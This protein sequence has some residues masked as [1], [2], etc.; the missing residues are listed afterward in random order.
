L[1]FN[2]IKKE[3][4]QDKIIQQIKNQIKREILKPGEKLPS[5][6]KLVDLLGVSRASIRE[7]VQA[8][9]FSGYL[10]VV[11]GKGTYITDSAIKQDEIAD[12]LSNISNYSLDYLMETRIILESEC[13]KYATLKAN[14][15][16]IEEIERLFDEIANSK[17]LN[18]FITKDLK[19][20]LAI[21]KATHNPIIYFLMRIFGEMIHKESQKMIE[22]SKKTKD[23]TIRTLYKLVQAIKERKEKKAGELMSEHIMNIKNSL[24]KY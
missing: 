2:T 9:S 5:E 7:A 20:H 1:S 8:L 21:A 3:C 15:E 13:A 14:K 16:E 10:D 11:Q 22:G 6:R 24:A 12:F 23:Q 17:S 4:T 18:A 19:F